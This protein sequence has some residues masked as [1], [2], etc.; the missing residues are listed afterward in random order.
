M[1]MQATFFAASQISRPASVVLPYKGGAH[2]VSPEDI[3]RLEADSNYTYIHIRGRQRPLLMA[4]VLRL[5]EAELEPYGFI[6]IHRAHLINPRYVRGLSPSG[7]I[8]MEDESQP[9]I[10]RRRRKTVVNTLLPA[11][12]AA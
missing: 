10:S 4:K 11:P 8:I 5:Y 9:E 12:C 2:R 1:N 7:H 3:I 6:R